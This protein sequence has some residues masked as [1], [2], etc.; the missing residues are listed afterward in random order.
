MT[1]DHGND[2]TTPSTDHS[3]EHVPL[4]AYLAGGAGAARPGHA[5]G[6][7]GRGRHPGRFLRQR[8][9]R[10][11]GVSFLAR[12][13]ERTRVV[14]DESRRPGGRRLRGRASAATRPTRVSGWARP[15]WARSGTVYL[16]TNVENASFGLSICAERSAVC[17]RGG[18]RARREFTAIAVC[19]DGAEPTPPCGACRQVL[20]EFGPRPDGACWPG[21][22][23]PTAPVLEFT[24]G[25]AA[26][27]RLRRL[28]TT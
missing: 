25:R 23:A 9:R 7:H 1:A 26:A 6:L 8:R 3:R 13:P 28:S 21:N 15:C 22:G 24:A 12:H 19:A 14:N 11:K 27:R 10:R 4:L 18:R 17:R 20:L 16:G 2:P 5:R